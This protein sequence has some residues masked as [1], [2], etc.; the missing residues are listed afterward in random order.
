MKF[1]YINATSNTGHR[2][3]LGHLE[4]LTDIDLHTYIAKD[5]DP[6]FDM[7][8]WIESLF[9][10][11]MSLYDCVFIPR[12]YRHLMIHC[13]LQGTL[14]CIMWQPWWGGIGSLYTY[15]LSN[16][17]YRKMM[18]CIVASMSDEERE[19]NRLFKRNFYN[20]VSEEK[21]K[22]IRLYGQKETP[23]PND[24]V[25][26]P[27][28]NM[29]APLI[30]PYLYDLIRFSSDMEVPLAIKLH[31]NFF[32]NG[33]QKEVIKFIVDT[34][35][36]NTKWFFLYF[37]NMHMAMSQS[38]CVFA[39]KEK[40]I[41][42]GAI[43]NACVVTPEGNFSHFSRAFIST[44]NTYAG[45]RRAFS[46][47]EVEKRILNMRQDGLVYFVRNVMQSTEYTIDLI[48][49]R[50]QGDKSFFDPSFPYGTM[51]EVGVTR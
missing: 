45:L 16:W 48:K 26:V 3:L 39:Y 2:Q 28:A 29:Q 11:D 9:D 36:S 47:S 40:R 20:K 31:P 10:K 12:R 4:Q 51:R 44:K 33:F 15:E 42:D 5:D 32:K 24:F 43:A 41:I 7:K 50:L 18:M 8:L 14:C 23:L 19:A 37:G 17:D 34:C 6:G 30:L 38:R 13:Q 22:A 25:L 35:E 27:L 46:I 49:K 21:D 1:L